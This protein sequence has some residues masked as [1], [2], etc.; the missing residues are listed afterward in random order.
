MGN[1]RNEYKI[2]RYGKLKGRHNFQDLSVDGKEVLKQILKECGGTQL[3]SLRIGS[4]KEVGYRSVYR[5][6]LRAGRPR[7]RSSS[8]VGARIFSMLSR[9]ALRPTH[10][11]IQWVPGALSPGVERLGREADHSP[12]AS[13]V[14]KKIWIYTSTPPYAFM[15]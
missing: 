6:W 10:R 14:V 9:P 5:D 2:C 3:V 4:R 7:G 8:P 12:P 11:P 13:A 15:T 1:I